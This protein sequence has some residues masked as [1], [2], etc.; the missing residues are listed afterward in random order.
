[1]W[2]LYVTIWTAIW[3]VIAFVLSF[4]WEGI[5]TIAKFFFAPL[6]WFLTTLWDGIVIVWNAA[7]NIISSILTSVWNGITST[8]ETVW[9]AL[10]TFISGAVD[11]IVEKVQGMWDTVTEIVGNIIS[12]I[13]EI[14]GVGFI[15]N[16]LD[17]AIPGAAE[18][19][20]V[21]EPTLLRAGEIE[22]E[23]VIP[24]SKLAD[25]GV[26]GNGSGFTFINEGS[27]FAEDAEEVVERL[28]HRASR[29]G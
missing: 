10:K 1:M 7:W 2:N 26:G 23:A 25:I 6:V 13:G 11:T 12:K 16:V 3:N 4:I 29:R 15:G 14:P 9:N 5:V 21:T 8:A 18:G 20:L 24:L 27:I 22:P 17:M 19:A 28:A